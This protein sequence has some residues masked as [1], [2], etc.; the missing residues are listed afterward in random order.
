MAFLGETNTTIDVKGR[1]TL[2][3]RCREALVGAE[4]SSVVF[5]A[6]LREPCLLVYSLQAFDRLQAEFMSFPNLDERY[7][8]LQRLL[9]G[10]AFEVDIDATG[11]VLVPPKL[12]RHANLEGKV[13]VIG[14]GHKFEVWREDVWDERQAEY[15]RRVA[16]DLDALS[17]ENA[18][19]V[20]RI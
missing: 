11:R 17:R 13:A 18:A 9:L 2:P 14:Q 8:R 4:G 3:A 7:R 15:R 19:L 12:R 5:A 6:D 10:S 1:I 20:A 16:D